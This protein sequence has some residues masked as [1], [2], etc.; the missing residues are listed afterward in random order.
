MNTNVTASFDATQP[1]PAMLGNVIDSFIGI[2]ARPEP[3][4][5]QDT[6]GAFSGLRR[7]FDA[8]A[9]LQ[10]SLLVIR[11]KNDVSEDEEHA[12]TLLARQGRIV[13][14]LAKTCGLNTHAAAI[15]DDEYAV[16]LLGIDQCTDLI[17]RIE[18]VISRMAAGHLNGDGASLKC[19]VGV[20][21]CPMDTDDL[22]HLIRMASAA[23]AELIDSTLEYQFISRRHRQS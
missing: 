18:N 11:V 10:K 23:A 15:G 20:A 2:I 19:S 14:Q 9:G 12:T 13:R 17:P 4:S 3:V 7:A 8:T 16:L 5:K 6:V 21:R 22:G 1:N